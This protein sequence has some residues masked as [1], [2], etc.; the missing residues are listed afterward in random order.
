MLFISKKIFIM[1][2]SKIIMTYFFKE[3]A[4]FKVTKFNSIKQSIED[5]FMKY[6]G[7]N[8]NE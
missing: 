4:K 5:I 6:Y 1:L 3:M 2:L 7:D 8:Q